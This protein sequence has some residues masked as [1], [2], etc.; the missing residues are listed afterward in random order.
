ML[1]LPAKLFLLQYV[2][3]NFQQ[4]MDLYIILNC[5]TVWKRRGETVT[6]WMKLRIASSAYAFVSPRA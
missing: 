1:K 4:Y 6:A 3:F 2:F 5:A